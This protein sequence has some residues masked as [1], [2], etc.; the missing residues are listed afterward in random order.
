MEDQGPV[1]QSSG[2]IYLVAIVFLITL[3]VGGGIYAF[4]TRGQKTQVLQTLSP[5][6][7]IEASSEPDATA[8]EAKNMDNIT[9]LKIEDEKVGSGLE[10]VA[11]KKVTV[12]YAGTLVDGT[13][14]D[15]SYDRGT[16]FS[17]TLGAGEVIQGWDK[18]FAGMKIGGKRRI[19]IPSS[20]GYGDSGIPG[21]IPGGA[22]LIFEVELLNVE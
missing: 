5:S 6:A 18:G 9:E 22:T 2:K 20:M 15:S 11:G 8:S 10:A 21:V 7:N 1:N 3:V 4:F 14:F 17:F 16:P 19:T 13:K 12:N